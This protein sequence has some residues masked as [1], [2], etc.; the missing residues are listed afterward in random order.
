[1]SATVFSLVRPASKS[2]PTILSAGIRPIEISDDDL[3]HLHHGLHGSMGFF[4][5]RIAQVT[6]EGLRHNLPGQAQLVLEPSTLRFLAAVGDQLVPEIVY[7]F[8]RLDAYEERDCFVEL[9]FRAAVKGVELLPL[10]LEARHEVIDGFD[11]GI[12]K[13]RFVEGDSLR[14]IVVEPEEWRNRSR[15][16]ICPCLSIEPVTSLQRSSAWR[17]RS[18]SRRRPSCPC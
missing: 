11:F 10:K 16:R 2:P 1:V 5:I 3:L 13:H 15:H 12:R 9:I 4:T 6:A 18:R 17:G 7:L 14:D 8:L